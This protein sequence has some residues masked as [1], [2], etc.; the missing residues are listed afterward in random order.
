MMASL[1]EAPTLLM[2]LPKE[3]RDIDST[4]V[5]KKVDKR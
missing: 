1:K 5:E 4:F 3:E 2:D